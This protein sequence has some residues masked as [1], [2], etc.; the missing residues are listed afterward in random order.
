MIGEKI[1]VATK[2][3]VTLPTHH[4][5]MVVFR[6]GGWVVY[7][8]TTH[9]LYLNTTINNNKSSKQDAYRYITGNRRKSILNHQTS[10]CHNNTCIKETWHRMPLEFMAV[11]LN[12]GGDSIS[13]KRNTTIGY[14]KESDYVAK[15]QNEQ[16]YIGEVAEIIQEKL[17]PMPEKLAFTFHHNFYPKPNAQLENAIILDETKKK[18]QV[19]K[20]NYNDIVSQHSSNIGLTYLEEMVIETDLELPPVATRPYHLPLKH[21]KIVKEEIGNLLE[22]RLTE[23][24]MSPYTTSVIVVLKNCKPG[25]PLAETQWSVFDYR[26]L[27]KQIPKVQTTNQN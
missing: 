18:L 24:S 17:P 22:A 13:I 8:Y 1:W 20:E 23:R 5:L 21:H 6:Y 10:K 12:Q 25:A 15:S 4:I 19:L 7:S 16:E 9:P 3:T 14:M 2:C 27:N 26:E 11:L